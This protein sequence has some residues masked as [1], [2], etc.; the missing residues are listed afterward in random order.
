MASKK[1]NQFEKIC[2]R[3]VYYT[4]LMFADVTVNSLSSIVIDPWLGDVFQF[5]I[6]VGKTLLL[7]TL[8]AISLNCKSYLKV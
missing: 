7:K 1:F 3:S 4:L 2:L 8:K 5:D 6:F